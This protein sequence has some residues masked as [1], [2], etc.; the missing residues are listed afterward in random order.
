MVDYKPARQVSAVSPPSTTWRRNE[1]AHNRW[2]PSDPTR[3][4]KFPEQGQAL[5]KPGIGCDVMER[6]SYAEIDIRGAAARACLQAPASRIKD[7]SQRAGLNRPPGVGAHYSNSPLQ[8]R[9]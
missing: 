7:D 8:S 1:P 4:R 9:L 3:W 2:M 5:P 6:V